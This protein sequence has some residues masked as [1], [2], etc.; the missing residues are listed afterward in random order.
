[1]EKPENLVP[2]LGISSCLLG[3]KVRYNGGHS[4]DRLLLE[5]LGRFVEWVPVALRWSWGWGPPGRVCDW[6]RRGAAGGIPIGKGLDRED[7]KLVPGPGGGTGGPELARVC[8][9]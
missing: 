1:M 2:R 6:C 5:S 8:P 3:E 9:E 4:R 7:G